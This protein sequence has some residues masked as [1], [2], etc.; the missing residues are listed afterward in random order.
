[1]LADIHSNL[2]A[3]HAVLADASGYDDVWV[4]GDIVGYGPHPH[5]CLEIVRELNA[6]C[7]AGNHDLGAVGSYPLEW[8]NQ[9]AREACA[10]TSRQ[11]S[12][13]DAL[14]LQGLPHILSIGQFMLVHGSPRQPASEYVTSPQLA[15]EM[16]AVCTCTHCLVGHT[17]RAAAFSLEMPSVLPC[18]AGVSVSLAQGRLLLNPGAV[19]QPRDGDSR[20]AYGV[21]D[22]GECTFEFHRVVYDVEATSAEIVRQGLPEALG[23]RLH[24]GY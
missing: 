19:G 15:T 4:L 20:A 18:Q 13:G 9:V 11:L 14:F 24:A 22:E 7:V 23:M 8:F 6:A 5:E 3:L 17:H 2:E 16:G 12:E 1:M 21:L 10:W